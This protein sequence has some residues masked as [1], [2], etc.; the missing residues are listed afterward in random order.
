MQLGAV[1]PV[2]IKSEHR[3]IL[4]KL[5]ESNSFIR[6]N[7]VS[8][9]RVNDN[10][11]DLYSV[12]AKSSEVPFLHGISIIGHNDDPVHVEALFD[13]GA[14][15]PA[16]YSSMFQKVKH[17]LCNWKP[18][19]RRLRMANGVIIASD[20]VWRGT[21][22]LGGIRAEGEFEVF[23]SKGGWTFLFGKPLLCQFRAVHNYL[24]D[25]VTI[26]GEGITKT[27][28]NTLSQPL[29]NLIQFSDN[30]ERFAK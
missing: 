8:Q 30:K 23:D 10:V 28:V 18:S 14:M 29:G 22:A 6:D 2:H 5:A 9:E 24:T 21:I 19:S 7:D 4:H 20:A 25:Q 1:V 16:M 12:G 27:I 3:D 11:I 15:V 17:K 26:Q 13:R